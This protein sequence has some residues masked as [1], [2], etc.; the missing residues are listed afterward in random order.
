MLYL[1]ATVV[2]ATTLFCELAARR[3]WLPYWVSRKVLH[4]VAIGACAVAATKI[5]RRLLLGIVAVAE[6]LLL[7]LVASG[8]L[9]RD[10]SG[11]PAWGIIW[12]PLA[13]MI[14]L[15]GP[16]DVQ[17][18]SFSM[19]TLALCDPAATIVGKLYGKDVYALTGDQ[20]SLQGNLAFLACVVVLGMVHP[21]STGLS[22]T[23]VAGVGLLLAA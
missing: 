20:K 14:L 10:E 12:F 7:G 6:V 4:V 1:L 21:Y 18:V 3:E 8:R 2:L 22:F 23:V 5:D 9:L 16:G 17:L 13:F 19:W 11:R 15:V